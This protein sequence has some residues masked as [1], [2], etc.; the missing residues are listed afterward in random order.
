MR[1]LFPAQDLCRHGICWQPRQGCCPKT[2][3]PQVCSI[4]SSLEQNVVL[5]KYCIVGPLSY[6][7]RT[8][9]RRALDDTLCKFCLKS[10]LQKWELSTAKGAGVFIGA[11]KIHFL[12]NGVSADS[13]RTAN[14]LHVWPRL[15]SAYGTHGLSGVYRIQCT[16]FSQCV[17]KAVKYV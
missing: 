9:Y 13:V 5:Y 14:T 2:E 6:I 3:H 16:W 1:S 12:G 8:S 4:F 15:L 10:S 11:R 7:C 17:W